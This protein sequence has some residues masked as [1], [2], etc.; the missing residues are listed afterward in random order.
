MATPDGGTG[1]SHRA[2][3]T[4]R[5]PHFFAM[6][7][8]VARNGS[9]FSAL[10]TPL[11]KYSRGES[12]TLLLRRVSPK[13]R[14]FP[15][16]RAAY[17]RMFRGNTYT[18]AFPPN[19]GDVLRP[20]QTLCIYPILRRAAIGR[21]LSARKGAHALQFSTIHAPIRQNGGG[22]WAGGPITKVSLRA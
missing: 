15:L 9:I 4:A 11:R 16:A 12:S 10:L 7:S 20:R 3:E 19:I 21:L 2:L 13:L 8:H 14:H 17:R 18:D 1:C 5:A 6:R 22:G